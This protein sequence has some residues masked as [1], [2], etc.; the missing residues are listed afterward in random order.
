MP[1]NK[2]VEMI[3]YLS[4]RPQDENDLRDDYEVMSLKNT[5]K[6]ELYRCY[7]SAFK[8]GDA[9]FFFEQSETERREYFEM[10]RLGEAREEPGS[11]VILQ[12]GEIIGFTLVLPNGEGNRHI[13]CMCVLPDFQRQGLGRFMLRYAMKEGAAQ[14]NRSI[15]LSTDTNMAAFQLYRRNGFEIVE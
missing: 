2:Y 8:D 6:E 12:N 1:E 14:G 7:Y 13:S 5:S 10:L 9:Q 11:S 15:T 3:C 4:E